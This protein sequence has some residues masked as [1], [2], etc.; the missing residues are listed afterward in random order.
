YPSLYE[1]FGL[2]PL[3]AMACGVPVLVSHRASLPEIVG[4]AR[5]LRAPLPPGA[6]AGPNPASLGGAGT[7]AGRPRPGPPPPPPPPPHPRAPP[8]AAGFAWERCAPA[9]VDAYRAAA[10]SAG[11]NPI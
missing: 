1:G 8:R 3:E 7:P 10:T 9:T 5:E 2:P 11:V 6:T 4:E